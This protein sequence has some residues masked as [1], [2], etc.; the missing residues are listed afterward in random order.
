VRFSSTKIVLGTSSRRQVQNDGK[1]E[2]SCG[3]ALQHSM[4][5][6]PTMVSCAYIFGSPSGRPALQFAG[7]ECDWPSP[8]SP[9]P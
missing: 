1:H 9:H 8:S 3:V 4:Q 5:E 2:V 7:H 6:R